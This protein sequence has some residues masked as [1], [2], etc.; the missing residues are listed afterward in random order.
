LVD[1]HLVFSHPAV[2]DLCSVEKEEKEKEHEEVVAT[3]I[4]S[5]VHG[6]VLHILPVVRHGALVARAEVVARAKAWVA[7]FLTATARVHEA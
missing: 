7:V 4:D 6:H 2:F 3:A 5:L 1:P